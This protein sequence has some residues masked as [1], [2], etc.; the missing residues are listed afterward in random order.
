MFRTFYRL[1]RVVFLVLGGLVGKV[2]VPQTNLRH[3]KGKNIANIYGSFFYIIIFFRIYFLDL[4]IEVGR[5]HY[6]DIK[7]NLDFRR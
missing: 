3:S 6:I 5:N 7:I 2:R 1:E 4:N